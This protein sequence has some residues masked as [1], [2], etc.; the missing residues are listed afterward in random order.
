MLPATATSGFWLLSMRYFDVEVRPPAHCLAS[1][2]FFPEISLLRLA[3][4]R[5]SRL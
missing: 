4:D 2:H 5:G 1:D 3:R